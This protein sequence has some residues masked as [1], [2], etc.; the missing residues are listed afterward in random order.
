[1]TVHEPGRKAHPLRLRIGWIA[2]AIL[3]PTAGSFGTATADHVVLPSGRTE[4]RMLADYENEMAELAAD[5]PD[6]VRR[7]ELPYPSVQGRTIH[8]MEITHDVDDTDA[9]TPHPSKSLRGKPV[10]AVVGLHHGNEAA[11]SDLTMEY[12]ISLV[13]EDGIDPE[14][15]RLLDEVRV[16]IVPL[17]NVDGHAANTRRNANNVDINRNYGFGWRPVSFPGPAPFSEP[18]TRNM[19]WL[20]TRYQVVTAATMHTCINIV[21]YPP[22]QFVAGLTEDRDRFVSLGDEMAGYMGSRHSTSAADFETTG[23]MIDWSYYATRGLNFTI[24]TCTESGEPRN[25]HFMVVDEWPGVQ[26]A[27][28]AGL[29]EAADPSQHSIIEGKA[30]S[31]AVLTVTKEFDLWTSPFAQPDGTTR[32]VRVPTSIETELVVSNPNG[33]FS[34]AVNP[35]RRPVPAYREDGIHTGPSGFYEESWTL[36]CARP[37]GT[38]LE[39][40]E[41]FVDLGEV[42]SVDLKECKRRFH[43]VGPP[44]D[45]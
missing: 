7:F 20:M 35:S 27:L 43:G 39:E 13:Q 11:S 4:H 42:E 3:I 41:V 38:V 23:E 24:E 45:R 5:N 36:A 29:R 37:D 40:T 22:L 8:G 19:E 28:A 6:L 25:F 32:P 30:P 9:R 26:R 12:A 14:V 21:L 16:V 44:A 2:L 15:T 33:K 10:F 17:V 31:G 18:E 34:W 1:M